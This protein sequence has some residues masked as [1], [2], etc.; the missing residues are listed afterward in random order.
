MEQLM[1]IPT[2]DFTECF[3]QWKK[4]WENCVRCQGD[5]FEGD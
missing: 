5:Y 2:K 4:Y 1:K 3:E